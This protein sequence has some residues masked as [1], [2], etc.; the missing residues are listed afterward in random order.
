MNN[1]APNLT[2]IMNEQF[3]SLVVVLV[4]AV[5]SC[6]IPVLS[7]L[8]EGKRNIRERER[9]EKTGVGGWLTGTGMLD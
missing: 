3:S 6:R 4:I 7:N 2:D 5:L 8:P 1:N 9:E